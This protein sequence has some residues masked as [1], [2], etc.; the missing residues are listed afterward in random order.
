MNPGIRKRVGSI[1]I[2]IDGE[3]FVPSKNFEIGDMVVY[4]SNSERNFK[5]VRIYLGQIE[6]DNEICGNEIRYRW[7]INTS[8]GLFKVYNFTPSQHKNLLQTYS[9]QAT[10]KIIRGTL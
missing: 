7:L 6:T 5:P 4:L 3:L 8:I 2:K 9:N 1:R 10:W